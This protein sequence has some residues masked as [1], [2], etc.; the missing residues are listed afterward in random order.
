[1]PNILLYIRNIL[2]HVGMEVIDS[3]NEES[4]ITEDLE[5][6]IMSIEKDGV[7][8]I[9]W[10]AIRDLYALRMFIMS[11]QISLEFGYS[12]DEEA[13]VIDYSTTLMD[14]KEIDEQFLSAFCGFGLVAKERFKIFCQI[15]EIIGD[16]D[17]CPDDQLSEILK[18]VK[19]WM[20]CGD[21]IKIARKIYQIFNSQAG[22]KKET[23]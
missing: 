19:S 5:E 3:H 2:Q 12:E 13:K 7:L 4:L 21:G 22:I 17:G 1:M 14:S 6:L 23:K 9:L 20:K 11:S 8:S 15:T 10:D 18:M 16:D